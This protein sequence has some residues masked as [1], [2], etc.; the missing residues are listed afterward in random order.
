[1]C[2]DTDGDGCDDC[3]NGSYN[4]A[5]DGFDY[6]NDGTCDA[7]DNDADNDGSLG[8]SSGSGVEG[9]TVSTIS[10]ALNT[11]A[12]HSIARDGAGNLYVGGTHSRIIRYDSNGGSPKMIVGNSSSWSNYGC[13]G[14]SGCAEYPYVSRHFAIW[15]NPEA[16]L[17]YAGTS[18]VENDV[19][20]ERTRKFT[21]DGQGNVIDSELLVQH[22]SQWYI[23]GIDVDD[24]GNVYI[25]SLQMGQLTKVKPDG[26]VHTLTGQTGETQGIRVKG[27]G[28]E[29]YT[30]SGWFDYSIHVLEVGENLQLIS[31]T[32]VAGGNGGYHQ[33]GT[34]SDVAIKSPSG[35]AMCPDGDLYFTDRE[36]IRRVH[37]SDWD[38]TADNGTVSTYAG[39]LSE[40]GTS[41]VSGTTDGPG[42]EASFKRPKDAYCDSDGILYIASQY[43]DNAVRVITPG[44]DPAC[45]SDD[46]DP[47]VCS[48]TDDDDCDDCSSGSYD[49]ANDGTDN[50]GDGACNVGDTSPSLSV[51]SLATS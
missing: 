15:I 24:A 17:M 11:H 50:D 37:L 40:D 39:T 18:E 29:I 31:K 35:Y 8:C 44:D 38:G 19:R 28:T 9:P 26:T 33:D 2:S 46:N 5:N 20:Y 7:S 22:P 13:N 23:G 51:P 16:T 21:L 49:V 12:A 30:I 27:D 10:L 3:S 6:D 4:V 42:L 48:D 32:R 47:N 36:L 41:S 43:Q 25:A 1:V 45:D 14:A 34:G